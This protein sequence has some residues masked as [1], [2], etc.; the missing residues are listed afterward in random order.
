MPRRHCTAVTKKTLYTDKSGEKF[1]VG[2]M[3]ITERTQVRSLTQIGTGKAAI[4][5]GLKNGPSNTFDPQMRI[6]WVNSPVQK[7]LGLSG[8]E[9]KDKRCFEIIYGLDAPCPGCKAIKALQ[10]GRS[11]EG[12][13][14][15]PDGETWLSRSNPIKDANEKITGVVH[16]ALNISGRKES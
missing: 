3:D 14:V 11:Q 4:L 12:E 9:I 13:L 10:T 1:I 5:G 16:V 6:I 7:F 8:D 2:N 15:T